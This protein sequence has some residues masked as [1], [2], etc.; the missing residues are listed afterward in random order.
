[1]Y[2]VERVEGEGVWV[3]SMIMGSVY[4]RLMTG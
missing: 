2:R 1:M 3:C 4:Q